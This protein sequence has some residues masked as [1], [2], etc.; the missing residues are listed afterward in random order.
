MS[1][2]FWACARIETYSIFTGS[3]RSSSGGS[4]TRPARS[5]IA[6]VRMI[7]GSFCCSAVASTI[8]PSWLI[9]S[10]TRAS[11]SITRMFPPSMRVMA[12]NTST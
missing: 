4:L 2:A 3:P 1:A 12:W 11:I 7:A 8:G 5:A 10:R 9:C 6:N